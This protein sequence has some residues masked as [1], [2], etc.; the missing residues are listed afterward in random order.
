[1]ANLFSFITDSLSISLT[2]STLLILIFLVHFIT[3]SKKSL[4]NLPP[5]PTPLP[6]IGNLHLLD[7]RRVDLS[8]LKLSEKY[9]P[10]FTIHLG[11]NK[12]IVLTGL[13]TIKEATVEGADT[14]SDRAAPP[15]FEAI[16]RGNGVFFSSGEMWKT[17]RRFTM[18]SMKNLGMGKKHI[19]DK[20]I[21]ELQFLIEKIESYAGQPFKLREFAC[22]PTNITLAMLFGN[23][24]DYNDPVYLQLLD[25]IDN[26]FILLGSPPLQLFNIYPMLAI[27]LKDHKIVLEKI[28]EICKVLKTY[29]QAERKK[30]DVNCLHTFVETMVA[31]QEEEQTNKDTFFHEDNL[32]ATL[33]DLVMAGTETTSTTLHWGILLMMKYPQVQKK[34]Q[35]EIASVLESGRLP[36]FEDRNAMPYTNAVIH[37]VQRF[38]NVIPFLP[39]A[40]ARDTYFKGYRIPKGAD[41]VWE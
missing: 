9:G 17:T 32:V 40:T 4:Y 30:F 29:I 31:K 23:R 10:I 6:L 28:D 39:R 24:F 1:M 26:I 18:T 14:F 19:E 35:R 15:I 37:E 13:E 41:F 2:L 3:R 38:A 27:F 12:T 8:L 25:L 36:R 33:L 22:G 11:M 7:F 5:G 21:E 34:V 16:Q 20:I